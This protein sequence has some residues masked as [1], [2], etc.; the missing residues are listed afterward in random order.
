M[1]AYADLLA[2]ISH[3]DLRAVV[4]HADLLAVISHAGLL[5]AQLHAALPNV[6]APRPAAICLILP[7]PRPNHL[8]Y[9]AGAAWPV[10][11]LNRSQWT[12]R[13][14]GVSGGVNGGCEQWV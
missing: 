6:A 1:N 9:V 10:S 2:V 8:P 4:S 11:N 5:A 7:M 13:C 14:E 12:V 3:A